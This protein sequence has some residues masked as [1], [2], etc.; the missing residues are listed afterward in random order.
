MSETIAAVFAAYFERWGITLPDEAVIAHSRGELRQAGWF[1]RYLWDTTDGELYLD[2]YATHRMTNDRHLRIHVDGRIEQLPA[3]Q[4]MII[5]NP[6]I[7]GD[8]ERARQEYAAYNQSIR[9]ALR[10]KG[11]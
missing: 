10:A 1:I 3:Y 5:H 6:T 2:L 8:E 7:P 11:W 9:D 4:D